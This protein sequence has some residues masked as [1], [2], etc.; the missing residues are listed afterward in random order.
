MIR[1][2]AEFYQCVAKTEMVHPALDALD[3]KAYCELRETL[4]AHD[5]PVAPMVKTEE[6]SEDSKDESPQPK[7]T[8]K[9]KKQVLQVLS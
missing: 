9:K 1:A 4:A 6:H 5:P 3:F 2:R 7:G 8:K